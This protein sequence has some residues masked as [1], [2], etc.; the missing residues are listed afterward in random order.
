MSMAGIVVNRKIFLE[1]DMV[2]KLRV[3][4]L[5]WKFGYRVLDETNKKYIF[6]PSLLRLR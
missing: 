4:D 5:D 2:K 6:L 1:G 3:H